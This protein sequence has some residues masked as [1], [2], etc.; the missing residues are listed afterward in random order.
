MPP[1]SRT[2]PPRPP[3]RTSPSSPANPRTPYH[4]RLQQESRASARLFCCHCLLGWPGS[5]LSLE[6]L[7]L[8]STNRQGRPPRPADASFPLYPY[9]TLNVN[10]FC[11]SQL[12]TPDAKIVTLWLPGVRLRFLSRKL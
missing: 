2:R 8:N 9:C 3:Q 5:Q 1:P 10:V 4:R 11:S 12:S 7:P 6:G